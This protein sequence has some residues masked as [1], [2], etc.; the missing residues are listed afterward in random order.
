[1]SGEPTPKRAPSPMTN[2]S[3]LPVAM[4][5]SSRGPTSVEPDQVSTDVPIPTPPSS[6]SSDEADRDASDDA[7]SFVEPG[8]G[9][10]VGSSFGDGD[11]AGAANVERTDGATFGAL[12]L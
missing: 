10:N 8:S 7:A 11:G 4:P 2:A 5:T 12:L 6:F 3:P 9:S 1:M